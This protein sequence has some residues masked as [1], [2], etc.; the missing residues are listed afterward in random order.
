M[1]EEQGVAQVLAVI[2]GKGGTGKT[3]LCA[4]IASCLAMDGLR[5]LCIDLDV[6]LRNLDIALGMQDVAVLP[7]TALMRGEYSLQQ[8]TQHPTIGNLSM[9]TAP[10]TESA[11][12]VDTEAFERLITQARDGFDWILL[13]APAGV[14]ALFRM[15]TRYADEATVV[16]LADPASQ[17]DAARAAE[18]LLQE[19]EIPARLIVNRAIPRLFARMHA[20]V[21]DVMDEVR[22]QSEREYQLASG[23]SQD[24]ESNDTVFTQT[25]ARLPWLLIGMVGGLA[26]S[27]ILG[28]FESNIAKNPA[29]ALFIPL[30]GGT[31]GNVGIQSSAIVV[32]G[33]AN[34]KL[35]LKTAGKQLFKELG[36]ALI[37]ACMISLLVFVYNWFFLD[38]IATT[39]SVSLSLFAVVIFASIFGTLVP[40]TLERFKIDPAIATGPFIT[41]TNDI[42][43]MLIYMSISYA[44]SI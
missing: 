2:S 31:G 16:A 22:E 24:V 28:N 29:T 26:N 12:A 42:I 43:G 7:F 17:R 15:A 40:L 14:G 38:N 9:L 10:V 1:R 21:D 23:L 30:I 3:S 25:A 27:V 4:G 34:G 33:L 32:Q 19:R 35:D 37:N 18:L 44:L 39:V 11:E 5:V 20:T 41:I 13:D 6:G 8:A 36:V